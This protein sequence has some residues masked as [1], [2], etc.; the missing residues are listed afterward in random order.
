MCLLIL[1][2]ITMEYLFAACRAERLTSILG[3]KNKLLIA[4]NSRKFLQYVLL[5][6][7]VPNAIHQESEG[8]KDAL[9][10]VSRYPYHKK[11]VLHVVYD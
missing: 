1:A 2:E 4:W 8:R 11:I 5:I 9:E 3:S 7:I 6:K 10:M